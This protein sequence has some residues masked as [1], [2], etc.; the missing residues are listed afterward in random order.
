MLSI[1][2]V[3]AFEDNY[4]WLFHIHGSSNAYVVDPGDAAPVEMALAQYKLD[5]AG[6]LITHHHPDH[7]GGIKALLQNRDIPVFG[8]KSSKIPA[9]THP[10]RDAETLALEQGSINF[11]VLEVPG[12]TLDHIAY[13]NPADE[14]LFCGDTLFAGGCGRMFEGTPSQMHQSLQ[15]LAQL[16]AK[17]RVYCAH[18]YTTAN[19]K[20]AECVEPDNIDLQTRI[21]ETRRLRSSD[22]PTVPSP[23]SLELATNPFLRVT[24]PS[25]IQAAKSYTQHQL[26]EPHEVFAALRS[27]KDNF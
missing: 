18:E 1:H 20:F 4:F 11:T 8:P 2:N 19:L 17:T 27:W 23:I 10:L 9:V 7:T 3:P 26:T 12:H 24:C 13:F 14:V 21:T 22:H 15:K 25:V 5:L 6:I 16:P